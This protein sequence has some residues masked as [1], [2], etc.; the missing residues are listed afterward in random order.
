MP[1]IESA[2]HIVLVPAVIQRNSTQSPTLFETNVPVAPTV[3]EV[4][5]T[6][7]CWLALGVI[8]AKPSFPTIAIA[9]CHI[10]LLV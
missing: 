2:L 5:P 7:I 6:K 10:F 1:I 3:P 4:D 9:S 8:V